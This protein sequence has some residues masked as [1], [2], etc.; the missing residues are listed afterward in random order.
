MLDPFVFLTPL[1]LV[2]I[3]YLLRFI[4][5]GETATGTGSVFRLNMAADLQEP[6][7]GDH[8]QVKRITEIQW[9]IGSGGSPKAV[10]PAGE[11]I[12]ALKPPF[13]IPKTDS[14]A[15]FHPAPG[16]LA[17]ANQVSCSC[18]LILGRDGSP[19]EKEEQER[20]NSL[21]YPLDPTTGH[22]YVFTLTPIPNN[23]TGKRDFVVGGYQ[24]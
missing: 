11:E 18:V 3:A 23:V 21:P 8:R 2:P 13:L 22:S 10:P 9:S 12:V 6:M 17:F 4:G 1:A 19:E 7:P 24:L 16:E 5:C 20:I 15:E 14:G